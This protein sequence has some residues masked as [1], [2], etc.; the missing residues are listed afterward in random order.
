M[1]GVAVT[2]ALLL[3]LWPGRSAWAAQS[4]MISRAAFAEARLWLLTD[5]DALFSLSE[6]DTQPTAERAPDRVVD[7]CA[8]GDQ[9][10]LVTG[11]R[12]NPVRWTLYSR[13]VRRWKAVAIVD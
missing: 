6:R 11:A 12:R 7:L 3:A 4:E 1:R 13:V 10:L 2:A 8:R 9:L 5:Q